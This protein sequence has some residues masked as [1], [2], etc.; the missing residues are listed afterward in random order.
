MFE[1]MTIE[2]SNNNKY[3]VR[4][5]QLHELPGYGSEEIPCDVDTNYAFDSL[6]EV[7]EHA[8]KFFP[9]E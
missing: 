2:K 9:D 8:D 7:F 1:R 6:Q 4:C 3:I 5:K